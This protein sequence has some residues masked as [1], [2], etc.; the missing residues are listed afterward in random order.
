MDHMDVVFKALEEIGYQIW[1]DAFEAGVRTGCS[2]FLLDGMANTTT[3]EVVSGA[4]RRDSLSEV[5]HQSIRERV[6]NY[7]WAP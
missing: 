3:D 6:N 1:M 5:V 4:A 2:L 7:I